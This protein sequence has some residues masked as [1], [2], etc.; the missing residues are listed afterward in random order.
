MLIL[1]PYFDPDPAPG[2]AGGNPAP[3]PDP[4]TATPPPG[5]PDPKDTPAPPT[6]EAEQKELETLLTVATPDDKQKA[7]LA[8]LQSKYV[9]EYVGDDGKPLSAE[10]VKALKELQAKVDTILKKEEKDRTPEEVKFLADNTTDDNGDKNLYQLVDEATGL[11]IKVEYGDVDPLSVDGVILRETQLAKNAQAQYETAIKT[12][13]PR[14]YQFMQHLVAG[15]KEED[16]FKPENQDFKKLTVTKEDVAGQERILRTA[17]ALKGNSPDLIDVVVTN[18]KD[19]GKLFDQSKAELEALQKSQTAREQATEQTAIR[20]R[21]LEE[22]IL[23]SLADGLEAA[24]EKGF[25]GIVIPPAE[26]SKFVKFFS[27]RIDYNNGR[28]VVS[29]VLDPKELNK[30]LKLAYFEFKG[31]DLKSL[32]ERTA[33]TL[34]TLKLKNGF[35]TVIKP[36]TVGANG[37]INIPLSQF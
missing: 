32:A 21:Q 16:F 1:K 34:N 36:K 3:G 2:G 9:T 24:V 35:K 5:G 26:R 4:K 29:K 7:R 22:Q 33:K 12:K 28:V 37:K 18:W 6:P 15:G 14:A 27:D 25:E 17:L 20:A 30:E 11:E 13:L 10:Q 8:E 31:G 19:T 23:G